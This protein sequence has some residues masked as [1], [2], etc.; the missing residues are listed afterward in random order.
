MVPGTGCSGGGDWQQL[1]P[2]QPGQPGP[3]GHPQAQEDRGGRG[4]RS[5]VV[6]QYP[7]KV[8]KSWVESLHTLHANSR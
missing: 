7:L 8:P 1:Q 3:G 2:G 6:V 4:R 5:V